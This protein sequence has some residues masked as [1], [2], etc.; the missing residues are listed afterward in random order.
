MKRPGL[1]TAS[2]IAV[3]ALILAGG[4]LLF[5]QRGEQTSKKSGD[6]FQ[7]EKT[8]E[9]GRASCRERVYVLV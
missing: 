8:D 2:I 4:Y 9:I 1:S 6:N 3:V 5:S 7:E